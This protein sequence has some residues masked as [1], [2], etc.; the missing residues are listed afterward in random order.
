MLRL[1]G[2]DPRNTFSWSCSS[3]GGGA[4][5]CDGTGQE[6]SGKRSDLLPICRSGHMESRK[7]GGGPSRSR[8]YEPC[9]LLSLTRWLTSVPGSAYY[10]L[11]LREAQ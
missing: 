9:L 1:G 5:H 4:I 2:G 3:S 8:G 6:A 10:S 7:F 11:C